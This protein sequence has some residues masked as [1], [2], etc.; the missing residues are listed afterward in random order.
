MRRHRP[1]NDGEEAGEGEDEWQ[2]SKKAT[3]MQIW[4]TCWAT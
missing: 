1:I 4:G 3:L 2:R